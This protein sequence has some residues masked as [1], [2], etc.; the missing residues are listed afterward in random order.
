[1][2][3][4]SHTGKLGRFPS[5]VTAGLLSEKWNRVSTEAMTSNVLRHGSNAMNP[6]L[7]KQKAYKLWFERSLNRDRCYCTAQAL[8]IKTSEKAVVSF[9]LLVVLLIVNIGGIHYTCAHKTHQ[10]QLGYLVRRLRANICLQGKLWKNRTPT[11][12]P[13]QITQDPSE[14]WEQVK[15]ALHSALPSTKDPR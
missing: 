7:I 5:R 1:M 2:S 6:L 4:T 14:H 11:A 15:E 10:G 8:L 13:E 3:V 9:L 12:S